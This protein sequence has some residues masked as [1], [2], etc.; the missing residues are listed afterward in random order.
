MVTLWWF[1]SA[2]KWFAGHRVQGTPGELAEIE[3][4]LVLGQI[5]ERFLWAPHR[6]V[7]G[8][9]ATRVISL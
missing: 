2:R 8:I 7:L 3:R 1:P 5:D 6:P 4:D 9:G